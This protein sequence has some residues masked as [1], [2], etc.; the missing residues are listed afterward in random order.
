LVY[1]VNAP[2]KLTTYFKVRGRRSD[3]YHLIEAEMV[4]LSLTDA[5]YIK[6][7]DGAAL[8]QMVADPIVGDVSRYKVP[9]DGSNSVM[10]ALQFIGITAS[11]TVRKRIPA[12]AGLGGG[13][14]DAGAILRA[15]GY[16]G[17]VSATA[18]L[19]ADVPPSLVGGH[20]SVGGIG[21]EVR[22]L[23]EVARN[24]V[25][26]LPAFSISTAAVYQ[27]FDTVGGDGGENDLYVAACSVE[28]RLGV[29][30]DELSDRFARPVKLAGSGSTLFIEG[31][32]TDLGVVC[33][34]RAPGVAATIIPTAVGPVAVIACRTV[35]RDELAAGR[36]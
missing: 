10:R 28:P 2:A 31:S 36:R 21:D 19:G 12:G 15:L 5:I 24:Y 20:V 32:P 22:L 14:S 3:G 13:S 11:V 23:D 4:A 6:D 1:R 35:G 16:R 33:K 18:V 17:D 30:A 26:F 34:R 25:L 9:V 29:L 8:V 27:T 7:A